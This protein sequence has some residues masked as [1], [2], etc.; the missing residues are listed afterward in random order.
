MVAAD[1]A[2]QTQAIAARVLARCDQLAAFTEVPGTII[3]PFLGPAMRGVVETVAGWMRDAGMTTRIDAAGNLVGRFPGR[4]DG[5]ALL[6]GSPLD[7]GPDAG[8]YDGVLG[9]LLGLACVEIR[10]GQPW[11]FAVEVVGFRNDEAGRFR[12]P[13]LGSRALAGRFDRGLLDL[14]DADGVTLA[15]AYRRSGL[16]PDALGDAAVAPCGYLGYVEAHVER[17]P[18]LDDASRAVGVVDAIAGQSRLALVFEGRA[19]HAGALPMRGRRDALAAASEFILLVEAHSNATAGLVGTVGSITAHPGSGDMVPGVVHLSLDLRHARD[20]TREAA[21][22]LLLDRARDLAADRGVTLRVD[23]EEDHPAVP[24]D[25][26]LADL[27]ARSVAEA[28]GEPSPTR[29]ISGAGHDAAILADLMPV[30][31]L[32]IRGPTRTSHRSNEQI[33]PENVQIVLEALVRFLVNIA[34]HSP[35]SDQQG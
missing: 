28:T 8:R 15:D 22:H 18:V 23:H 32:S 14:R 27:L 6:I 21:L 17:G 4:V 29:F 16:D 13:H 31:M 5:P 10:H 11:P 26:H 9:V 19:G 2:G 7:T 24:A 3:R 35:G 30:A 12:A 33:R 34:R 1:I 25:P 20:A